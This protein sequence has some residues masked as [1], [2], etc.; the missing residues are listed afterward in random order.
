MMAEGLPAL[1]DRVTLEV[2]IPDGVRPFGRVV[3]GYTL[4]QCRFRQTAH[5]FHELR[6][7][8]VGDDHN[9]QKH[10]VLIEFAV[11]QT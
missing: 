8:F 5:A 3:L 9:V 4:G 2:P 11:M 6:I 10:S 7:D 1:T